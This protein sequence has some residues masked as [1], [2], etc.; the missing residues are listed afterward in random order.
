MGLPR[1]RATHQNQ[2]VGALHEGAGRQLLNLRLRQRR[3]RPVDPGQVAVDRE[4]GCLHLVT[5]AAHL[6]I[7][8][9]GINQPVQPGFRLHR[10]TW[11]LSQQF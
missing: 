8:L 10:L 7:R 4:T 6:S 11:P 1:P 2:V 3:F 5:Q 9:F